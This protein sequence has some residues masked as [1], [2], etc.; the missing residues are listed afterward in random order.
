MLP[1]IGGQGKKKTEKIAK[2]DRTFD[3]LNI[4][5][6]VKVAYLLL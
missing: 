2:G 3:G 4:N 6:E 5:K 1:L